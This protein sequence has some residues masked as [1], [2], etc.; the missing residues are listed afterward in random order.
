MESSDGYAHS[1]QLY[2]IIYRHEDYVQEV[3]AL[4]DLIRQHE[5]RQ[6]RSLLDVACGTGNH[7]RLLRD[8]GFDGAGLERNSDMLA[9]ARAKLPAAPLHQGDMRD[10]NLHQRFDVVTCLRSSI[11]YVQPEVGLR[12]ALAAMARHVAPGGLLSVEPWTYP[13]VAGRDRVTVFGASWDLPNLKIAHYHVSQIEDGCS[14]LDFH[15]MV[16][17]PGEI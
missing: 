13:E 3:N 6:S 16:A 10:F 12:A 7:L 2:D 8:A 4:I 17:R 5:R 11:A 14:L 9:I 15:F 1:V